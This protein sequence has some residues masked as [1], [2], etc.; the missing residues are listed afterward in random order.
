MDHCVFSKNDDPFF[1]FTFTGNFGE[2]CKG[3]MSDIPGSPCYLVA[4]KTLHASI[5]GDKST[6]LEEAA[7]MAQFEHEHIVG[8]HGVVTVGDPTMVI[9]EYCEHGSLD[10]FVQSFHD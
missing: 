7:V 9:L 1:P 5:G 2:V 3:L 6:L 8:L 4:I 10:G